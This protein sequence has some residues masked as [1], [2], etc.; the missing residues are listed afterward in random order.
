MILFLDARTSILVAK[1]NIKEL[2]GYDKLN[3]FYLALTEKE[4]IRSQ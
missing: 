1:N 4:F 3:V 2:M